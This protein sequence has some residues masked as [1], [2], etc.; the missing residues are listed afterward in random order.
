MDASSAKKSKSEY[1]STT[2][3]SKSEYESTTKKSKSKYKSNTKKSK[4]KSRLNNIKSV[5]ILE[6]IFDNIPINK[7]LKIIQYNKKTQKKLC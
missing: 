1:E 6:K 2:K 3:N 5:Y 7:R 4:S